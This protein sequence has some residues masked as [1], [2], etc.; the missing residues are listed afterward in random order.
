MKTI[1]SIFIAVGI[2]VGSMGWHANAGDA[3]LSNL[4]PV[5]AV[6]SVD[7]NRYLGKWYEIASYP[8]WFQKD[9]TGTTASYSLRNDGRVKVINQ[10][11]KKALDGKKSRAEG[12]AKIIDKKSNARLSV[13]FIPPYLRWI[14]PIIGLFRPKDQG[15]YW[16]IELDSDY[17]WAVVGHP[18]RDYLWILN[19]EPQIDDELFDEILGRIEIKHQF[20]LSRLRITEQFQSADQEP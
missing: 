6:E 1:N 15:N 13:N 17:E 11:F 7:L 8:Q 14:Q 2:S 10:C 16:I 12:V 19:R 5:Q 4:A 9:C 18:S 3:A 20:D